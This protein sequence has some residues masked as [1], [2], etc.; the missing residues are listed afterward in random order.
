LR[1]LCGVTWDGVAV[2]DLRA[3]SEAATGLFAAWGLNG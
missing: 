3:G 1:L 2:G